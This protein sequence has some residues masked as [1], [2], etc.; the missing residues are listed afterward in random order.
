M[1]AK[2]RLGEVLFLPVGVIV[3]LF[4]HSCRGVVEQARNSVSHVSGT[5]LSLAIELSHITIHDYLVQ[6]EV[7]ADLHNFLFE[8]S[9]D[10]WLHKCKLLFC[11]V[12]RDGKFCQKAP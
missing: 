8:V 1:N 7:L 3:F 6:A 2:N 12:K 9:F 11:L 5:D 4:F 10:I